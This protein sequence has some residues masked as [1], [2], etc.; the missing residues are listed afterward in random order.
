VVFSSPFFLFTYLPVVLLL[1]YITPL[2]WRNGVLLLV[3]LIFYGWGEPVYILIMFAS[4]AID[5]THGMI[6]EKC[7]A[8]GSDRGARLAVAS[9]VVFNLAL[10]FYF[11][12]W[13]FLAETLQSVGLS[14][15]PVR[16][17]ELPIGISF[18][19]FQTMSYTID[20][21][22][23]DARAQHNIV[24]FGTF[25]TLFPQ[26]I[27][28]PIIKYKDLGDQIDHRDY[29]VEQFAS[30]VQMFVI[31]LGKK[32]LLANNLGQLWD[33]YKVM[34]LSGLTTAGAWLG[35]T[36]FALQI[37]FDFSGYS[38]M[39]VGL[40]RMLGFEFMRNFDYPFISKSATEFWRRWHISLGTWFREYVYFPLGGSRVSK[41]RMFFNLFLV[42]ALTGIW[43]GASWNYL[44]WGLYFGVVLIIEKGFLLKRL[45][46][47]PAAVQHLYTSFVV[48]IS[49]ALFAIE[50]VG[51]IGPYLAAM[52]GFA[53]G[54]AA[55]AAAGYYLRSY[56]PMLVIACVAATP[57][58][59]GLWKRLPEKV[60][61]LVLPVLLLGGLVL[62]TAYLVDATYNPFLYFRF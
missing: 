8:R 56:L 9:S 20:V 45:Q 10:L 3:N 39:A 11:K 29:R 42:W 43:H 54:G 60:R 7:K 5:Y 30:G 32:V 37:Y 55:N 16:G 36:A 35:L 21:Y 51:R 49:W 1:H 25:V 59:A 44:L 41:G 57:L 53:Q 22:R 33:V 31:G 24:N 46:R 15:M 13:D 62:S 6:V 23:G 27:A 19:T 47:T 52:F 14:F 40:G 18:Y 28:G 2:R 34:D 12:Y 48:M 17:I 38:D 4:I 61:K 50:D 26:L 58:A